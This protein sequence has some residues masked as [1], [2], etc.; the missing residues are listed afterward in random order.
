[1]CFN[2]LT[3][4][5]LPAGI[6]G[7]VLEVKKF[8]MAGL[9]GWLGWRLVD[10]ILA[11]YS[12]SELLKPH[13]SLGDMIAPVTVRAAKCGVFLV[14]MVYVIYQVGH[15]D[16]LGRFLTGLGVAGL[17]AS[18]AAQDALKSFFGTLLLIGERHSKSATGSSSAIRKAWWSKSASVRRGCARARIRC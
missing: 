10:L 4:L 14:V 6:F 15:F 1:M 5:D 9:F 16:L 11:V 7:S 2:V 8:I 17:A 3:L 18:L 12:G 13:R